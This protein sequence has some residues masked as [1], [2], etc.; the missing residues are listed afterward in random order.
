MSTESAKVVPGDTERLTT[1]QAATS[2]VV[3]GQTLNTSEDSLQ[4]KQEG[5]L[6]KSIHL[7]T[8]RS[9]MGNLISTLV[10]SLSPDQL[11]N[12]GNTAV[13]FRLPGESR[14]NPMAP[15]PEEMPSPTDSATSLD[16]IDDNHSLQNSVLWPYASG[17][18]TGESCSDENIAPLRIRR[19]ALYWEYWAEERCVAGTRKRTESYSVADEYP[20]GQGKGSSGLSTSE[21]DNSHS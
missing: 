6:G 14:H 11:G 1:Y 5:G 3:S 9:N 7:E 21:Y 13:V 8:A 17:R 12:D 16:E 19:P 20:V 10:T 2:E 4:K 18:M 15:G